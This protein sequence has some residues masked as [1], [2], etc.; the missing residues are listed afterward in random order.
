MKYA[1]LST[2]FNAYVIYEGYSLTRYLILN[3]ITFIKEFTW[4]NQKLKKINQ[5]VKKSEQNVM[6]NELN[7]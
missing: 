3:I 1:F 7:V 5:I 6:R 4:T 2:I